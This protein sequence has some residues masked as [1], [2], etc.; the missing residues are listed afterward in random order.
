MT[1]NSN[2][3]WKKQKQFVE[4]T[5]E[6]RLN[7]HPAWPRQIF[8]LE[9]ES[10]GLYQDRS[11]KILKE[12]REG[13]KLGETSLEISDADITF[14]T[15]PDTPNPKPTDNIRTATTK[16]NEFFQ[17]SSD[18]S[19]LVAYTA[20]CKVSDELQNKISIDVLP[21]NNYPH[22]LG[23]FRTEVDVL[24]LLEQEKVP[25]EVY[26]G[27]DFL[28]KKKD[29]YHSKKYKQMRNRYQEE[30]PMRR[31]MLINRRADS[32]MIN[33]V[34]SKFDSVAIN[35]DV[36]VGC[37]DTHSHIQQYIDMLNLGDIVKL[38]PQ[39]E[40]AEGIKLNGDEF[41]NAASSNERADEIRPESELVD[42]ASSLPKEYLERVRGGVQL[43][44]VNTF[45]RRT[46]DTTE[47]NASMVLQEIY[48]LI[49]REGGIDKQRAMDKGWEKFESNYRNKADLVQFEDEIMEK[50]SKYITE[51]KNKRVIEYGSNG[52]IYARNATHPQPS[53]SF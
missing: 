20:L 39:I 16:V 41:K 19:E 53:F 5:V 29:G 51:L 52:K 46:S 1:A 35:T 30:N 12:L 11:L 33:A 10:A 28:S 6:S 9:L 24:L 44:Y 26:N 42:A 43:H 13:N 45:Y 47:S 31:P 22:L 23:G 37:E 15:R 14:I 8:R 3:V 36:I 50:V 17:D 4:Q 48:N 7:D 40:T 49:L 34:R 32:D 25:V 38:I 18:F 27:S 2:Q 21:A